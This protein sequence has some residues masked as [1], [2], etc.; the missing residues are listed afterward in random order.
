MGD[1]KRGEGTGVERM[2]DGKERV[3][4]G[5]GGDGKG[6]LWSPKKSLK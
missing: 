5:K 2:G 3:R 6:V 4:E 1:G